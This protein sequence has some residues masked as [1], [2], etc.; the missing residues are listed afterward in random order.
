[1]RISTLIISS[2]PW[3][4]A[5]NTW[6]DVE[7]AGLD[8]AYVADHLTHPTMTGE[9]LADPWTTLAV[10]A[11][12]TTRI[13]LGTLVASALIRSPVTLARQSSTLQ[14][15]SGGRFTLGVGAG[16]AADGI[17]DRGEETDARGR[18][19]R[20]VHVVRGLHA[21]WAGEAGYASDA[22]SFSGL[23]TAP[24]APGSRRPRLVVAAHGNR[25]FEL[26]ATS[27]DGWSTYGGA[28]AVGAT[29]EEFW[30]VVRRQGA[31]MDRACDG[32]SNDPRSISRSVLVGYAGY[33]PLA[34]RAS[35]EDEVA[36]AEA[37]GLDELVCYW[38]TE[39]SGGRFSSDPEVLAEVASKVNGS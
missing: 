19:T 32:A 39:V 8:T 34:S 22:V 13:G 35:L 14:D 1:M 20:L 16:A 17:A 3:S 21:V 7:A 6:G 28:Q 9:W 18:H 15:V 24:L 11:T 36:A 23:A 27:A 25:G 26:V 10:A 12:V 37:C 4:E 2:Q 5:A 31:D 29:R 30:E 38:P 33:R